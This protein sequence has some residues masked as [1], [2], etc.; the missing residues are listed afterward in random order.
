MQ[1]SYMGTYYYSR[2][3]MKKEQNNTNKKHAE[4]LHFIV[5]KIEHRLAE[6]KRLFGNKKK[7]I[8][9]HRR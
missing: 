7:G 1:S 8:Q 6:N 9:T 4:H 2:L 5:C 3:P